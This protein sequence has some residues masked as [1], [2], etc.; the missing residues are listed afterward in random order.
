[1]LAIDGLRY[2]SQYKSCP[3]HVFFVRKK[4]RY[5]GSLEDA[6]HAN[7]PGLPNSLCD[8][9]RENVAAQA[10]R[11]VSKRQRANTMW[12]QKRHEAVD[13]PIVALDTRNPLH[14]PLAQNLMV[15]CCTGEETHQFHDPVPATRGHAILP[16]R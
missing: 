2:F 14:E 5:A 6:F 15:G 10:G 11:P 13:L 4:A 12:S 1:M 16:W 7:I 9:G 8:V 3:F